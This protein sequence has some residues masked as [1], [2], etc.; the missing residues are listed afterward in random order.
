MK[1]LYGLL[2][3]VKSFIGSI[4][5]AQYNNRVHHASRQME[6]EILPL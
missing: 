2:S 1:D 4:T 3:T 6:Y 5:I